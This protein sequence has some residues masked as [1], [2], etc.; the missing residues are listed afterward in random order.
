MATVI[1]DFADELH[2]GRYTLYLQD[3]GGPVGLCM[4]LSHPDRV[5]AIIAQNAVAH[6]DGLSKPWV[7]RR[8]FFENRYAHEAALRMNFLSLD[9]TRQRH[10][11]SS[12]HPERINPDTWYDE[13]YFL[14]QPGEAH[15]QSEL[16]DDYRTNIQLYPFWQKSV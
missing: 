1:Q 5:E 9:A 13:Y 4:A 11:G 10:V 6:E 16:F 8:A 3:C 12:P 2:L 7:P 15:I 14:N